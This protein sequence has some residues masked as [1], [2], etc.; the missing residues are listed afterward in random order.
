MKQPMSARGMRMAMVTAGAAAAIVA[1]FPGTALAET[2]GRITAQAAPT[3]IASVR[4]PLPAAQRALAAP[5]TAG[6]S[7]TPYAPPVTS[8]FNFSN[9][10]IAHFSATLTFHSAFTFTI[11]NVK[12]KDTNCDDRSV[13][14]LVEDQNFAYAKGLIP[15]A[16]TW[17]NSMGCNT[18]LSGATYTFESSAEV[19]YVRIALYAA[20]LNGESSIVYSLKHANPYF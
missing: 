8:T 15:A 1:A 13:L 5:A 14:A 19:Q 20:N 16:Y 7:V 6:S 3:A 11:S 12:L 4:I 2:T 18:T 17:K 9:G 10:N